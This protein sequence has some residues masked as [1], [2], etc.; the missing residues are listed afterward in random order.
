MQLV[1]GK[2]L[3]PSASQETAVLEAVLA[4]GGADGTTA[5]SAM[6]VDNLPL[7]AHLAVLEQIRQA[8]TDRDR[9]MISLSYHCVSLTD[10]YWVKTDEESI[11]FSDINLYDHTLNDAVVE[12]TLKGR[13]LIVTNTINVHISITHQRCNRYFV[14][15][16][17][18]RY[19]HHCIRVTIP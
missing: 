1:T 17:I 7:S 15:L 10:V 8:V 14:F 16:L 4:S 2:A 9:A 6:T 5:R 18:N 12:L 3:L 11:C 19:Q 13:Q